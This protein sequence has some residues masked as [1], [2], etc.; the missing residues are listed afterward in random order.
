MG[1]KK[2]ALISGS[3]GFIGTN[4]VKFLLGNG[5][6]VIG[7][8]N[9]SASEPWK[10]EL[11]RKNGNYEF[12]E[13]DICKPLTTILKKSKLLKK[14]GTIARVYNL[15]CP[16]SPPRYSKLPIETIMVC[17]VGMMNMLNVARKHNAT[18]L[19][20][21]TSEVYGDPELHPQ[22]ELYRGNV[23]TV[24]PRSCYDEGKRIAE[25][26]CY[27][28]FRNYGTKVK[29]VRI[30][31]TY[32]PYMDPD[33]G[34]VVTNFIRQ[35]LAGHNITIYGEGKQTRSFQ[36]I[37]DLLAGFE[38]FM[39]TSPEFIG[40][41]NIGNPDEFT[42]MELAEKVLE[43]IGAGSKLS[44]ESLP[45]DDPKQRRPDIS[46]AKEKLNWE[47]RIEL[48]TGLVRTIDYYRKLL[49]D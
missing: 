27:E 39:Q 4:L 12:F 42:V 29:L 8:D 14:Y 9:F 49:G 15:A 2:L 41:V 16:A 7:V 17:S 31:N 47:P 19:H 36:F 48:E 24:G 35:A 23:N 18:I 20:A 46:L 30:F 37:D 28:Y 45:G 38:K 1:K 13:H 25:T 34:R 33:D 6:A 40:P 44:Y 11:F 43:L 21:S 3:A 5:Y 32:G 22:H 26:I 10:A